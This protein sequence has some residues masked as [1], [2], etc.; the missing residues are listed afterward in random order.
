MKRHDRGAPRA[1]IAIVSEAGSSTLS[2]TGS[3]AG[4]P[5]WR[6]ALAYGN[7]IGASSS[8]ETVSAARRDTREH[9]P[10]PRPVRDLPDLR[11]QHRA[12]G[13][14]RALQRE[15]QPDQD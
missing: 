12:E 5:I 8:P 13:W 14:D 4:S 2:S 10:D 6:S 1:P 7:A 15:T 9:Q 3:R 11:E